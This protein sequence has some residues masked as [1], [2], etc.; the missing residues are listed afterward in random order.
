MIVIAGRVVVDPDKNDAA[1][2]VAQEMMRE[3]LKESGCAAYKFSADLTERGVFH[4]FEEWEN[5]AALDA[6]FASPHMAKFQKAVGELGVK[7]LSVSRYDVSKKG[8]LSV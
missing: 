7:E 3:T 5:Q 6:H 4:I 2:P 8:P 1:L